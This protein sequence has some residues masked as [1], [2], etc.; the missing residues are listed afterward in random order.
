MSEAVYTG[1]SC[2]AGVP[3]EFRRRPLYELTAMVRDGSAV[4][5]PD[6][7]ELT[8]RYLGSGWWGLFTDPADRDSVEGWFSPFY[9]WK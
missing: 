4:R 2:V 1:E 3:F 8:A 5:M 9:R 7:R 6:G